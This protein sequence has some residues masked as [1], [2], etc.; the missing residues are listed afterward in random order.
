MDWSDLP[1]LLAVSRSASLSEAAQRLG[2][3][4]TTVGRRLDAL[5]RDV[6]TRLVERNREGVRLTGAGEQAIVAIERMEGM[7]IELERV[8]LGGDT[9]LQGSLRVT[10]TDTL[11][12]YE[13]RLFSSFAE[14]YPHVELGVATSYREHSLRKREADVAL[15][16]SNAPEPHLFGRRMVK[17][18][19]ALY[20][21]RR[22]V[23][24][25]GEQTPLDRFPWLAWDTG[26]GARVTEQWMRKHVSTAK[27]V[28]RFDS[29]LA[30]H[31]AVRAG[32]GLAF[33]PCAWGDEL[34][35]L[36]R[37]RPIEIGF[38]YDIWCLTHPDLE[39]TA[40]VRAFMR[41]AADY[42]ASRKH[43][44]AGAQVE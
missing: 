32:A 34:R 44:Y 1:I 28:C 21:H 27:V 5:E 26:S 6:A 15:R 35:T 24:R 12:H 4:Q 39:G 2:V 23:K 37:I 42:F 41:H 7:A 43:N 30:L 36:V 16:W 29:A 3:N 20:G 25:L 10:T 19:Y 22:L 38:A 14:R 31:A 13:P 33:M 9:R 17:V 18:E 40:R 8:L 11:V